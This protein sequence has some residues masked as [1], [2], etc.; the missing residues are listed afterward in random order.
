M[1]FVYECDR[2]ETM[3]Q[4]DDEVEEG[5]RH[6]PFDA[7]T[8]ASVGDLKYLCEITKNRHETTQYPSLAISKK[9][10][11]TDNEKRIIFGSKNIGGWTCLMYASYYN[12]ADIARWLLRGNGSEDRYMFQR[13][14]VDPYMKNNKQRNALMLAAS[15]GNNE[16]VEAI[17]DSLNEQYHGENIGV[18]FRSS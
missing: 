11:S 18:V 17:L 9:I 14:P 6:C 13:L 8:A 5:W 16:T 12:H 1:A 7:W 15:C 4:F 3:L 2:V 10:H